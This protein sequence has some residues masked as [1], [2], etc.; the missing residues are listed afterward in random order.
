[1]KRPTQHVFIIEDG[2]VYAFDAVL[3]LEAT[4][5]N[6]IAE[7]EADVKNKTHTNYAIRQP[8]E[9]K[10]EVS[11]SDTVTAPGEPLT[12]GSGVRSKKAFET[13]KAM[14]ERRNFLT[15]ITPKSTYSKMMIETL[16]LEENDDYQNEAHMAITFKEMIVPPK[17]AT[18]ASSTSQQTVKPAVTETSQGSMLFDLS[19]W[20]TSLREKYFPSEVYEGDYNKKKKKTK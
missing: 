19:Q 18:T 6:K 16:L 3:K 4:S 1:M 2:I 7:E 9:V 15:V 10:M 14:K 17:K 20:V 5:S 13:M 12:K 8:D 11:V